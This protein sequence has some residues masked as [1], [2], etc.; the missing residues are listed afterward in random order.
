MYLYL[1]EKPASVQ[2]PACRNRDLL[3]WKVQSENTTPEQ[4][5]LGNAEWMG[6]N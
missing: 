1:G 4:L 3:L 5:A 2:A 6:E